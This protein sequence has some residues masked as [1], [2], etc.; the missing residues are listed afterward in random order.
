MAPGELATREPQ[1]NLADFDWAPAGERKERKNSP[2]LTE[3]ISLFPFEGDPIAV[4]RGIRQAF[5]I[6]NPRNFV[7][8]AEARTA[9][10][11]AVHLVWTIASRREP[12]VG[13]DVGIW[14][15][16][17]ERAVR[18][19]DSRPKEHEAFASVM[20]D[21]RRFLQSEGSV[22]ETLS[23]LNRNALVI[24]TKGS[25]IGPEASPAQLLLQMG[26][27]REHD[28][29]RVR[30]ERRAWVLL[31]W[32]LSSTLESVL[33]REG[34]RKSKEGGRS[35]E[36]WRSLAKELNDAA[37]WLKCALPEQK[38]DQAVA[39]HHVDL[40]MKDFTKQELRGVVERLES[41][42]K[43]IRSATSSRRRS[44]YRVPETMENP[45][46]LRTDEQIAFVLGITP[47][48]AK[49]LIEKLKGT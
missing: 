1:R 20:E 21:V 45:F 42:A 32:A 27:L 47:A 29:S 8:D 37:L 33:E 24:A 15:G 46:D 5:L 19:L 7:S 13:E 34:W 4:V 10:L 3:T 48:R 40:L 23:R 9:V 28:R 31:A 11:P 41:A 18:S 36:D 30:P 17:F 22:I 43:A 16:A 35:I 38:E 12:L 44:R 39:Q 49:V 2:K 14:S 25:S 6:N 26:I